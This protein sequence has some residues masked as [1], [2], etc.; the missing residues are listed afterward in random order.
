MLCPQNPSF[1]IKLHFDSLLSES[2]ED[3]MFIRNQKEN[4]IIFKLESAWLKCRWKRE[5]TLQQGLLAAKL[6]FFFNHTLNF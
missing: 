5:S 4:W 2:M 3:E 6:S 1:I